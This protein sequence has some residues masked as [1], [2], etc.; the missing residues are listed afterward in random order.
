MENTKKRFIDIIFRYLLLSI[1]GLPNLFIF[2]FIFTP[3]TIY[4]I[5][6]IL[7]IFFDANLIGNNIYIGNYLIEIVKACVA[8]S[9]YYL[10]LILN[11][12]TPNISIIKRTKMVLMSFLIFLAINL[13]RIIVLSFMY[14]NNSIYFDIVHSVFWILMSTIFV[15]GIW[16]YQVKYYNINSTPFYTDLKLL[17]K[18]SIFTSE[19]PWNFLS[20]KLKKR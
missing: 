18:K 9:A 15:V 19:M 6:Y 11:L 4:P 16:F 12:S 14:L 10:L 13:F 20:L 3:L 2:Y 8:G 5:F 17:H 1:V 7:N